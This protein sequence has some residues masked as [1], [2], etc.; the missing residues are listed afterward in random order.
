MVVDPLPFSPEL[1]HLNTKLLD[2]DEL[3]NLHK[4]IYSDEADNQKSKMN[5][6]SINSTLSEPEKSFI[7][8]AKK[9]RKFTATENNS[10]DEDCDKPP[11]SHEISGNGSECLFNDAGSDKFSDS[12]SLEIKDNA[13]NKNITLSNFDFDSSDPGTDTEKP[14]S[15]SAQRSGSPKDPIVLSSGD[16][17]GDEQSPVL[18]TKRLKQINQTILTNSV[19]R[20]SNRFSIDLTQSSTPYETGGFSIN[21]TPHNGTPIRSNVERPRKSLPLNLDDSL[22]CYQPELPDTQPMVTSFRIDNDIPLE[23]PSRLEISNVISCIMSVFKSFLILTT[24]CLKK[25]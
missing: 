25:F 18:D 19:T 20:K 15:P 6:T 16:S 2:S 7:F 24:L 17:S 4:V 11:S 8:S 12:D 23:I 9:I 5:D 1:I 22:D 21:E 10:N 3:G 14:P 13:A